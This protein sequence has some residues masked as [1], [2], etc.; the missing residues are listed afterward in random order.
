MAEHLLTVHR[1]LSSIL[2]TGGEEGKKD[3]AGMSEER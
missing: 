3:R 1:V 2:S